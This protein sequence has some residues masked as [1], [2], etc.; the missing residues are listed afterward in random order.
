M[1]MHIASV[2]LRLWLINLP[3]YIDCSRSVSDDKL[4]PYA[5]FEGQSSFLLQLYDSL[6]LCSTLLDIY[7]SNL[8]R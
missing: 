5:F 1:A 7:L 6:R 4:H 2:V 8:C 3:G